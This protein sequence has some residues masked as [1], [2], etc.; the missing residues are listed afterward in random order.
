M[1]ERGERACW[2]P[3]AG[4]SCRCCYAQAPTAYPAAAQASH[5]PGVLLGA[6]EGRAGGVEHREHREREANCSWSTRSR[7]RIWL[8]VAA[9][10]RR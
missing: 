1:R 8:C 10:M 2:W 9:P 6:G 5:I 3:S 4:L 7:S